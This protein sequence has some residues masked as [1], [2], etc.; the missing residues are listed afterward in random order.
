MKYFRKL[1]MAADTFLLDPAKNKMV[2][3]VRCLGHN[4]RT[5]RVGALV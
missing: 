3:I 4:R 5:T 1:M 2:S